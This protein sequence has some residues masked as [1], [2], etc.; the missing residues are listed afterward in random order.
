MVDANMYPYDDEPGQ[1]HFD[2]CY[3]YRKHHNCAVRE[4]ESLTRERDALRKQLREAQEARQ[5]WNLKAVQ[6]WQRAEMLSTLIGANGFS[7]VLEKRDRAVCERDALR[8]V[9]EEAPH[10]PGCPMSP[11][12]YSVYQLPQ[13]T[14]ALREKYENPVCDCF[15]AKALAVQEAG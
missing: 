11:W 15:K 7:A 4:I 1:T 2:G 14:R 5:Q 10:E 13:H 9:I 8:R 6:S 12:V 3:R